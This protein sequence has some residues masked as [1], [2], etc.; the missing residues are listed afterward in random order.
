MNRSTACAGPLVALARVREDLGDRL[1][2]QRVQRLVRGRQQRLRGRLAAQQMQR[3]DLAR[4]RRRTRG[5]AARR[6]AN[7]RPGSA[8]PARTPR[9]RSRR[10]RPSSAR[11]PPP[12][13]R[14]SRPA[15]EHWKDRLQ[16]L[17]ERQ[18]RP[19][20]QRRAQPYGAVGLHDARA[21]RRRPPAASRAATPVLREQLG[22]DRAQ[23][24]QPL[25]RRRRL[26][27]VLGPA[28]PSTRPS[29]SDSSAATRCEPRSRGPA[30]AR[31]RPGTGSAAPGAPAAGRRPPRRP[32][33]RPARPR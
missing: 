22:D 33:R 11:R 20:R 1:L 10:P 4:P 26:G 7:R 19:A 21:C 30:D 31:P 32:S 23:P 29:R 28:S 18:A 5:A 8:R 13:W 17:A 14:R 24:L 3:A 25:V 9:R 6:S 27:D 12:R 15:P 2:V 16:P